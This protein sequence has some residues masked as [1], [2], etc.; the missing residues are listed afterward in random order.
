MRDF[1]VGLD[2]RQEHQFLADSPHFTQSFDWSLQ[3]F[4]AT[5]ILGWGAVQVLCIFFGSL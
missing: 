4:F 1:G 5:C 2:S 3:R